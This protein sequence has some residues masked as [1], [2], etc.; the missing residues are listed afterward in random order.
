MNEALRIDNLL[1]LLARGSWTLTGQEALVFSQSYEY[2]V[3]KK[4]ELSKPAVPIVAVPA[5]PIE[6]MKAAPP[7]KVKKK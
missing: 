3:A 4:A 6:I 5:A 7:V 2:L 1:K